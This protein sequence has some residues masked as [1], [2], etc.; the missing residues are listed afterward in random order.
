MSLLARIFIIGIIA[1]SSCGNIVSGNEITKGWKKID[2]DGKFSFYLPPDM[3]DT[4][5]RGIE[6]YHKEYTNG[7]VH[8]SFDYD[9]YEILAYPVRP[10]SL[11]KNFQE[12]SLEVDGRKAFMFLYETTDMRKRPYYTADLSIGDLP[13][14]DVKLRMRIS[15]WRPS[16]LK[17]AETIFRSIKFN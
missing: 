7:K 4:G 2:A 12:I 17:I 14:G 8:V 3:R 6:N 1:F 16:R 13:N 11:G 10:G 9:P 15:C 5:V